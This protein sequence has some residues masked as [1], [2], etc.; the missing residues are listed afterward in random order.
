MSW[1]NSPLSWE[2]KPVTRNFNFPA[3]FPKKPP[4]LL[5]RILRRLRKSAATVPAPPPTRTNVG[6]SNVGRLV[7]VCQKTKEPIV[8]WTHPTLPPELVRKYWDLTVT[9]HNKPMWM[10]QRGVKPPGT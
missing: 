8:P 7:W 10:G 1:R 6:D 5:E 9:T 4:G 3:R 2:T